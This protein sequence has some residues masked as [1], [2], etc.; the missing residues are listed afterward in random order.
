MEWEPPYIAQSMIEDDFTSAKHYLEQVCQSKELAGIA[1]ET[2]VVGGNAAEAIVALAVAPIDLIVT[3]SHRYSGMKRWLLGSVAEKVAQHALVL[4]F[5]LRDGEM[6]RTRRNVDRDSTV[7]ALVPLDNAPRSQDVL[8]PA[9]ELVTALSP[10]GQGALRLPQ[11]VVLPEKT[12]EAEREAFLQQAQRNLTEIGQNIRDGLVARFGPE[13]H[14]ALSW[15]VSA[16]DNIA[17]GIVLMAENGDTDVQSGKGTTYDFI[18]LTTHGTGGLPI[19]PVGSIAAR[20][21]HSTRLPILIVRPQDMIAKARS[22]RKH[23]AQM[24]A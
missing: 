18:A 4:V 16:T 8:V 24:Q 19:W 5:L 9:A 11:M 7:R 22:Q 13:L 15:S 20:V 14:P 3:S 17:E 23:G 21:L 10:C 1:L 6:V 2:Q 12:N